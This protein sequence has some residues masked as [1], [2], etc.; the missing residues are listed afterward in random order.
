MKEFKVNH[1][2]NDHLEKKY[3]L[4]INELIH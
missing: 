1:Y 4:K 3:K 2:I